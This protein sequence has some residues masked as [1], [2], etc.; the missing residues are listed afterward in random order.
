MPKKTK[1][2]TLVVLAALGILALAS[3]CWSALRDN[4]TGAGRDRKPFLEAFDAWAV[5]NI[6]GTVTGRTVASRVRI[7]D[8]RTYADSTY[9]IL[10]ARKRAIADVRD[11][12]GKD[13]GA[14]RAAMAV[15]KER[16]AMGGGDSGLDSV[17]R[18][19]TGLMERANGEASFA[20]T[21]TAMASAVGAELAAL[22][23]SPGWKV[24]VNC[25]MQD[26]TFRK[27]VLVTPEGDP[28]EIHPVGVVHGRKPFNI[29]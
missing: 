23:D 10:T 11:Y 20:D 15:Q 9:V 6:D 16:T 3:T 17:E 25:S 19:K 7:P 27:A 28:A 14:K 8:W 21:L 13:P 1:K 5:E 2:G 24:T 22:E 18:W 26:G 12:L 29:Q 4:L